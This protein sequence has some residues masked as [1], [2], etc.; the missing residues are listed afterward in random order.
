MVTSLAVSCH[1]LRRMKT[2]EIWEGTS[3]SSGCPRV[4]TIRKQVWVNEQ[5]K[6]N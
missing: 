2:W 5:L 4:L 3:V 1:P 6:D